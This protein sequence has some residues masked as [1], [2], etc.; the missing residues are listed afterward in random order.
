L[1]F[2]LEQVSHFYTPQKFFSYPKKYGGR[3]GYPVSSRA[4]FCACFSGLL[5][6]SVIEGII[7]INKNEA[8]VHEVEEGK[9]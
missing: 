7:S 6:V 3:V 4:L 8:V 1:F 2:P 5:A 9:G